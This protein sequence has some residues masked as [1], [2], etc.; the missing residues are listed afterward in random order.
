M[1]IMLEELGKLFVRE[2]LGELTAEN[3]E[4]LGFI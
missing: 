3:I 1:K 4:N 2:N